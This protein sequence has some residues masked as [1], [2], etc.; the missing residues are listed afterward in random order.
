MK[1]GYLKGH[2]DFFDGHR[3]SPAVPFGP[4]PQPLPRI[5]KIHLPL[6]SGCVIIRH[7]RAGGHPGMSAHGKRRVILE[8]SLSFK[9][10]IGV[11]RADWFR[12][13]LPP[14]RTGGSP[15]YYVA[16]NIRCVMLCN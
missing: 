8:N 15:D 5:V 10:P 9:Y 4:P 7:A 12:S 3:T 1:R 14:N 16:S 6:P 11:G 13:P 2:N